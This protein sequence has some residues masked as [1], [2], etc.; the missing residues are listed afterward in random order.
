MSRQNQF[1]ALTRPFADP[2]KALIQF[3]NDKPPT[4]LGGFFI[5]HI[6]TPPFTLFRPFPFP[7]NS[8]RSKSPHFQRIVAYFKKEYYFR[9][10]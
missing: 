5:P 10:L 3:F 8:I 4:N 1:L 6:F 9:L 7:D 2:L